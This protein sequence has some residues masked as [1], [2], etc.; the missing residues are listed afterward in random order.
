MRLSAPAA[1]VWPP[2]A[3]SAAVC[4]AGVG[5][6]AIGGLGAVALETLLSAGAVGTGVASRAVIAEGVIGGTAIL[7]LAVAALG[8]ALGHVSGPRAILV[9]IETTAVLILARVAAVGLV[10]SGAILLVEIGT[11]PPGSSLRGCPGRDWVGCRG[12]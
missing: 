3:T 7:L 8:L 9:L 11:I 5:L 12:C 2:T 10:R 4:T 1:T 6:S